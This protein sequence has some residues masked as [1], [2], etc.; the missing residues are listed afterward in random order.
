MNYRH[1]I[2]L[3]VLVFATCGALAFEFNLHNEAVLLM[4]LYSSLAPLYDCPD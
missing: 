1:P 2:S 4:D 3:L